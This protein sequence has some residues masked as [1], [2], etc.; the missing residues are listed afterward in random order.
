MP[1]QE[2]QQ[3]DYRI[4][5]LIGILG[6]CLPLFLPIFG[7]ELLS[8]MSHYYYKSL[9]SLIFIIIVSSFGLFLISYK[10]YQFDAQTERISDDLMTNIGGISAL[11]VV[12]VPTY[13]L[14]SGSQFIVEL[15]AN[16]TYPLLGHSDSFLNTIHLVAAGVFIFTMGWMSK[17]K[18]TRGQN[19]TN[20]KIYRLCGNIVWVAIALLILLVIADLIKDGFI[21]T[22]YDVFI[23]E[24]IAVIPFAISWL[25]KG[26]AMEALK[27]MF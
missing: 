25:I 4:R 18:F 11:I 9:P 13:C 20:N 10:G 2:L 15:C 23:L 6:L 14:E 21:I 22:P 8:S 7:G 17:Y 27:Q 1:S 19:Q 24:T 26:D 5:K 12:F 3:S 16:K